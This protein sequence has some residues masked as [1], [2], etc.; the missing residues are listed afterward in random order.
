MAYSSYSPKN[1]SLRKPSSS[2]GRR[3]LR[4]KKLKF[5]GALVTGGF[6][7]FIALILL[8]FVAFGIFATSLPSPDKLTNRDVDQSTKIYDRNGEL[9][10]D[11]FGNQNRTLVPLDE[12]PDNLKK[13]TIA[14]EDKNFYKHKGF[15]MFGI[16][17]SVRDIATDHNLVSGSTLTQQ[18][19]KNALLSSEQTITRKIKEFILAIEIENRYSKDQILQIYLNEVPYGGTAWGVEA[20]SNLYF[21]K[22]AKDLN[23]AESAILAGLPQRP[24]TY[25]PFGPDPKAY[26]GR[27][28]DVLRRMREESFISADQEKQATG[29]IENY[30]FAEQDQGIKAA[31]FVIYVKGLLEEKFGEQKVLTGGLRVTTTLDYKIQETAQKIVTAEVEKAQKL[32]V[33]NGA[34]VVQSPKTGEILAM[35]GSKDYFAKDYD[36]NVNVAIRLRQP[37]SSIKPINYVTGFK[38]GYTPATMLLDIKTSFP[39]GAGQPAYTPV[40]YDGKEHGPVQIRYALGNSYNIPAVK[41]L[42]LNTV[43]DMITTASDMGINTFTEENRYGLSL[44]LGGGEVKLLE[45]TNAFSVFAN[46]GMRVDPVSILKI[47]DSKGNVLD[48]FKPEQNKRQV[49]RPEHAFMISD[50]LSD[51]SAK[52][53]A[54][55]GAAVENTLSVRGKTVAVKTGT[56]DD[57]RDNWTIGYS[58][59]YTVGV[60]VGNNDN[61]EMDPRL[62]SGITGA[63]P[64]WRGIIG[65]LLKDK[66]DEPFPKPKDIVQ[67]EVDK[68]SGMLPGPYSEKRTEY[69]AKGQVPTKVDDMHKVTRICK[70]NGLP[71]DPGCE[72]TGQVEEKVYLVLYDPLTKD[73]CTGDCP[74][75]MTNGGAG[76]PNV[77]ITIPTQDAQVGYAFDV[78]ATISSGSPVTRADFFLDD[79]LM[80]SLTNAPFQTRYRVDGSVPAGTHIIRVRATNQGGFTASKDVLVHINSSL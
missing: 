76:A 11:I 74:P 25:S 75:G 15:D 67:M 42:Q 40:N 53:A 49:L 18:V 46:G 33:G 14:I 24:S 51:K 27:A 35:V 19:V 72:S 54:F 32:K 8:G 62:A 52:L 23:L 55:G 44:T 31:H 78:S 12:I 47:T 59:S 20:A 4:R 26:I 41:M 64:I 7:L 80:T 9:L 50:I 70:L 36:G 66:K 16:L 43:K 58:P 6:I 3:T 73:Y 17:R 2:F 1:S 39:G 68:I 5:V 45:L 56:T 79:V 69:F 60:W 57:K 48:E 38:K 65:E 10:Y 77:V 21:S 63:A 22:H 71:A 13:A 28:K 30:K 61:S 29:E 34:A 37:G